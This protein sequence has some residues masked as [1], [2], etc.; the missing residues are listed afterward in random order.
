MALGQLTRPREVM[1]ELSAEFEAILLRAMALEP[2]Q[3][4]P[5]V[6]ALGEAL[7]PFADGPTQAALAPFFRARPA[8]LS[9]PLAPAA[10]A[11]EEPRGH[12]T[13]SPF[14]S[15]S[16]ASP[17]A[18]KRDRTT[19]MVLGAGALLVLFAVAY[20]WYGVSRAPEVKSFALP[21]PAPS[22]AP[23]ASPGDPSPSESA[24]AAPS[25]SPAT[26]LPS[27]TAKGSPPGPKASDKA[28]PAAPKPKKG[29][30]TGTNDAPIVD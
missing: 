5:H 25:A 1:P 6:A 18:A 24:K 4:F 27:P 21:S 17:L 30:N 15:L 13:A 28:K 23:E 12:D 2:A 9:G 20:V 14:S 26:A 22:L 10:V 11:R 7:L 29:Y 16:E 19:R 8:E 3:R